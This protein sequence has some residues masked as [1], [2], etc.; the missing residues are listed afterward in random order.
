[1]QPRA[2]KYGPVQFLIA[3]LLMP[4]ECKVLSFHIFPALRTACMQFIELD[5]PSKIH[6]VRNKTRRCQ[7]QMSEATI[8]SQ[9]SYCQK[10]LFCFKKRQVVVMQMKTPKGQLYLT[11][12]GYFRDSCQKC[13]HLWN[14]L[15]CFVEQGVKLEIHLP[16]SEQPQLF[17]LDLNTALSDKV[18]YNTDG[19]TWNG[20]ATVYRKLKHFLLLLI[21]IWNGIFYYKYPL[22]VLPWD[23]IFLYYFNYARQFKFY[24][25]F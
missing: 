25:I 14:R 7:K 9:M 5:F 18:W 22:A 16:K 23:F 3:S 1:M 11:A 17:L 13:S 21:L 4:S 24:M 2:S 15:L 6:N 10:I 20:D 8:V 19:M 12:Q